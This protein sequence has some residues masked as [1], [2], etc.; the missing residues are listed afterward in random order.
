[1]VGLRRSDIQR[2]MRD[3]EERWEMERE[4]H[5]AQ[6]R[7]IRKQ[8]HDFIQALRWT[9]AESRWYIEATGD[10]RWRWRAAL[11]NQYQHPGVPYGEARF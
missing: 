3:A 4:L 10:E 1:M 8:R 6:V 11:G 2:L 7:R 5:K 9:L